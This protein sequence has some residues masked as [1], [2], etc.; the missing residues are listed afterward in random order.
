MSLTVIDDII[1]ETRDYYVDY[2]GRLTGSLLLLPYFGS[3]TVK[4]I[5]S[6]SYCYLQKRTV[7]CKE[8]SYIGVDGSDE[9]ERVKSLVTKRQK[10]LQE[11][12]VIDLSLKKTGASVKNEDLN[13]TVKSVLKIFS[14]NDLWEH[15]IELVGSW[16]FNVYQNY[17][18]VE[19]F[20]LRTDDIDIAIA[21]P[22]KG[23]EADLPRLLKHLGFVEQFYPNGVAFYEGV[24]LKVEFIVPEK[25]KGVDSGRVEVKKLKISAQPLRFLDILT[26][27]PHT[28]KIRGCGNVKVP[29]PS[30]F[31][32]HKLLAAPRRKNKQRIGK[33]YIQAFY[34]LKMIFSNP[35]QYQ[36]EFDEVIRSLHPSWSK[37][38]GESISAMKDCV[39]LTDEGAAEFIEKRMIQVLEAF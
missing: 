22:Y 12:K 36:S 4:Q 29:A 1:D 33:D 26:S 14:D 34:V 24:G 13:E 18:N 25:G 6:K 37:Q 19:N 7:S 28:I 17:L 3:V 8:N 2:R 31:A 35:E 21:L 39:P 20:P 38:I 11:I 30:A 9:V 15:G 5:G 32:I 27:H 16:C 10:I 23:K